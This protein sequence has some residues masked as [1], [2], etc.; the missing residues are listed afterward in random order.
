MKLGKVIRCIG[1]AIGHGVKAIESA[2][3]GDWKSAAI[4]LGAMIRCA[5]TARKECER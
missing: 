2:A 1:L 3:S 4:C 5:E